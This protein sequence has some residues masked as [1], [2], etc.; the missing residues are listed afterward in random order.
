MDIAAVAQINGYMAGEEDQ[1]PLAQGIPGNSPDRKGIPE[2]GVPID[3]DA[4]FH[5]AHE[6]KTGAVDAAMGLAAPA[7]GHPSPGKG[8]GGNAGAEG[9]LPNVSDSGLC[10][11]EKPGGILRIREQIAI[12]DGTG[13]QGLGRNPAFH[14]GGGTNTLPAGGLR[15]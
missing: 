5:A 14:A 4:V 3:E 15:H 8:G 12:A 6:G 7:I 2:I 11:G 1:I 13:T 10:G 9:I